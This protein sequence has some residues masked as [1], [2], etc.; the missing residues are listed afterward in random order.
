MDTDNTS[1]RPTYL[2][3]TANL[4]FI[5]QVTDHLAKILKRQTV[6]TV[7]KPATNV[8]Q[9]LPSVKESRQALDCRG[10]YSIT[11][12]CGVKYIGET[13][14]SIKIRIQEHK[15]CLKT[16]LVSHSA[17]AEQQLETG[18]TI[19]FENSQ[20]LSKASHFYERKIREAIEI[21]RCPHNHNR[22]NGYYLS[23]IWKPTLNAIVRLSPPTPPGAVQSATTV[24]VSPIYKKVTTTF[25]LPY[26]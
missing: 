20:V 22:D 3:S 5:P 12:S 14:W 16:G 4:P 19:L 13:G 8:A 25:L 17:V 9:I 11:S 1:N 18:H 21:H 2:V 26:S 6:E 7:F 23:N 10:I 24:T 15:P